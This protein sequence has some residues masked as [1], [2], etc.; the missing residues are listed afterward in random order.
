M[1]R[2]GASAET[3][4]KIPELCLPVPLEMYVKTYLKTN[5][6]FKRNRLPSHLR[7][8]FCALAIAG[9][10]LTLPSAEA[11]GPEH[12]GP[13]NGT[14][15]SCYHFV[16]FQQAGPNMIETVYT[17]SIDSAVTGTFTGSLVLTERDVIHPGGSIT[18]EG[19]GFFWSECGTL[20]FTYAGTGNAQTD[21]ESAHFEADQGTGCYAGV[22]ADGTFQGNVTG[23]SQGCDITWAGTYKGFMHGGH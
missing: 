2:S 12:P 6:R 19:S 7:R 15:N 11:G 14:F 4:K 18:F 3:S 5:C 20:R 9:A 13:E 21:S 23:P 1:T 16:N 8:S 10:S 17:F 22:Y